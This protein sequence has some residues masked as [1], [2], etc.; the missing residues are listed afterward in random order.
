SSI[1]S[2]SYLIIIQII[3]N[4]LIPIDYNVYN[5]INIIYHRLITILIMLIIMF[6]SINTIIELY[7][8]LTI[9]FILNKIENTL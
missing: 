5:Q 3:I 2:L 4:R 1:A 9:L 8:M 6:G 7:T